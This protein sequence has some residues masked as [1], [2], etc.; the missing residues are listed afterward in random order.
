MKTGTNDDPAEFEISP[1]MQAKR[2]K[3]S[4]TNLGIGLLA[5]TSFFAW[6]Y[7]VAGIWIKLV[8]SV[9]IHAYAWTIISVALCK[10]F[11]ILPEFIDIDCYKWFQFVI[12]NLTAI[13]MVGIGLLLFE[14]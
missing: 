1:E 9:N 3:V 7:I 10:V 2:D 6:G 11:N 5:T 4:V 13:S 14:S 12:K 8:P